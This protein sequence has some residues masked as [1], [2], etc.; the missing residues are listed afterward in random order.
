MTTVI[1]IFICIITVVF[2]ALAFYLAIQEKQAQKELEK[3]I[4]ERTEYAR[5]Q[6]EAV[7]EANN[8]KAE[9][10]TGNIERDLDYMAN[11]LHEYA[12]K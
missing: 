5:K 8:T 11:R 10:R 6:A 2:A 9:A 3:E 12:K 7:T 4:Q 1:S